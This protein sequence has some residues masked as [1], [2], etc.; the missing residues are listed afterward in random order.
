[1][2][3]TAKPTICRRL[4]LNDASKLE[5]WLSKAKFKD[6]SWLCWQRGLRLPLNEILKRPDIYVFALERN[7]EFKV[8]IYVEVRYAGENK[9]DINLATNCLFLMTEDAAKEDYQKLLDYIMRYGYNIGVY[10]ADFWN[11]KAHASWILELCGPHAK[12]ISEVSTPL[13]AV[14]LQI[15]V[16]E[17]I[18]HASRNNNMRL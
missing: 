15:N 1:M 9:A 10:H 18:E 4:T 8:V 12:I 16:K 17:Y 11:L 13:E 3:Q 14:R 5:E 7:G 2:A 6:F